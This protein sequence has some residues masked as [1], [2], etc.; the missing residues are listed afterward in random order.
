MSSMLLWAFGI[1][2]ISFDLGVH[3]WLNLLQNKNLVDF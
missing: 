3:A 1:D 2:F